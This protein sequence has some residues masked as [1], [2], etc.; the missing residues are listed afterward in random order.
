MLYEIL[1]D[2]EFEAI[3]NSHAKDLISFLIEKE[4]PFGILAKTE[5]VKFDPQLPEHIIESFGEFT[6]F[7]LMNYT[8]QSAAVD[9]NAIRF[10]A[11]FGAENFGSVVEVPLE[12]ILQITVDDTPI[13]VNLGA[14]IHKKRSSNLKSSMDALL[15]NPENRKLL[16]KK[17]KK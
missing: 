2:E 4:E 15:S 1:K 14:T 3:L 11:G 16:K 12:S 6:L 5:N 9:Q 7:L 13:F 17:R 10:E 8:L